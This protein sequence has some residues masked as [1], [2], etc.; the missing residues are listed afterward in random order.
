MFIFSFESGLI[1]T[2]ELTNYVRIVCQSLLNNHCAIVSLFCNKLAKRYRV[3]LSTNHVLFPKIRSHCINTFS[4]LSITYLY[5][6]DGC[7]LDFVIINE[8]DFSS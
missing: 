4:R 1:D 2:P 5:N 3:M 8:L 6:H 7:I